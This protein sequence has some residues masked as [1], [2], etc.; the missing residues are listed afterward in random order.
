MNR[1]GE[2]RFMR[3]ALALGERG[4]G[5]TWPNPSVGCV[6]VREGRIIGRGWTQ[7]GGRPHAEMEALARAGAAARGSTAYVTLE[8]C[9]NP[10]HTPPCCRALAEAG[11]ARVVAACIDPDPR[12][13]GKGLAHLRSAGVDVQLGLLAREA[14][15]QHLGLYRRILEG[16]PMFALKLA[17]SLDGRIATAC[18][19]SHWVS[20][21]R[22]RMEA[23]R[24]R[25]QHDAILIGSGTALADDPELTCRLPGLFWAS[26][27][28]ILLDRR[29]RLPPQ[30][31]L[32][33]GARE[34]PLWLFT[35]PDPDPERCRQL[36]ACG[37]EVIPTPEPFLDSVARRLGE[38]GITRVLVEGGGGV[39]GALLRR[40]L[41][42]RLH[43]VYAP[44]WLG[45]DA[46]PAVGP[47]G[48]ARVDEARRWRTVERLEMGEDLLITLEPEDEARCSPGS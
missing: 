2:E 38:R 32:A 14:R 11:V 8:P 36:E 43:L 23:H 3:V 13:N 16:R 12:V 17:L 30:S 4:L 15:R 5:T 27:V 18:G 34:V 35:A 19:H 10:G 45:G 37:V 44:I 39:A 26:P 6:L 7:P 31:K 47:L 1:N 22:A 48:L 21:E 20:G 42:D 9:A 29:L 40:G 33:L 46:R 24:L 41:V 25:A 28:R